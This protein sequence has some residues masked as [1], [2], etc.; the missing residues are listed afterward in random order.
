MNTHPPKSTPA[1]AQLKPYDL[2]RMEHG[3]ISSVWTHA[4][5]A[6]FGWKVEPMGKPQRII[7][8]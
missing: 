7:G 6:S 1:G 3:T 4:R 8:N 2:V 5:W